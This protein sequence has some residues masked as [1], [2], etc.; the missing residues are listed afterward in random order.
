MNPRPDG[1][2]V[3]GGAQWTYRDDKSLWY[4]CVDDSTLI[5]GASTHFDGLM[6]REFTGW[7]D[8]EAYTDHIWTGIQG[9]T[10]DKLP[11]V[12]LVQG[13]ENQYILAGYNGGGNSLV[14]GCAKG[15]AEMIVHGRALEETGVPV[16]FKAG[17]E[18]R[19]LVNVRI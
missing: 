4:D 13:T 14:F 5:P 10:P 17:V 18:G 2:I 12:G 7:A 19:R 3:V 9:I 1:S 16:V 8:S 15:V 11:H 6:Q